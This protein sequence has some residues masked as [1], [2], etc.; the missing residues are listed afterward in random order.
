[1]GLA[2]DRGEAALAAILLIVIATIAIVAHGRPTRAVRPPSAP[3][4]EQPDREGRER[5]GA[6]GRILAEA[7]ASRSA[8]TAEL[9]LVE[10]AGLDT[11]GYWQHRNAAFAI[12]GSAWA[13]AEE[14]IRSH[15][16]STSRE[17][18]LLL[19]ERIREELEAAG[20]R[21]LAKVR[22][23]VER[24]LEPRLS[25]SSARSELW[26][27]QIGWER[28]VWGTGEGQH[29]ELEVGVVA[30]RL[31]E[32]Y[33]ARDAALG[34][35]RRKVRDLY[36][37]AYEYRQFEEEH[38]SRDPRYVPNYIAILDLY[39][40]RRASAVELGGGATVWF[41]WFDGDVRAIE[42]EREDLLTARFASVK[43]AATDEAVDGRLDAALETLA[44][45]ERTLRFYLELESRS[46]ARWQA[47]V[48]A[49]REEVFAIDALVGPVTPAAR[50]SSRRRRGGS[51]G[52]GRR[53]TRRGR[54]P[55]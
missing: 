6:A 34:P 13:R 45:W 28:L 2:K 37:N 18:A 31:A 20:R 8:G 19:Q 3:A 55:G 24:D 50:P 33:A 47:E 25:W 26:V 29:V 51:R 14:V 21:R 40:R 54:S 5:D 32:D 38:L 15:D 7:E 48:D 23:R 9:V 43:T 22:A 53:P 41:P 44:H 30:G 27:F 42:K 35:L 4:P 52:R 46:L 1:L 11:M 16:D 36:E 10:E 39:H 49:A 17:P 12:L